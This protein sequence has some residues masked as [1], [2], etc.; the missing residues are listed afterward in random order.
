MSQVRQAL[1]TAVLESRIDSAFFDEGRL[2]QM[3]LDR[4]QWTVS[5]PFER[6]VGLKD[7]I[8]K[9]QRWTRIDD[10]WSYFECDWKPESWMFGFR[11][12]VVRQK[13]KKPTKGPL[14]LDLFTPVSHEYQ[15][16]VIMTNRK[17]AAPAVIDF[18][19]GRGS[20]EGIFA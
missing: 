20:Q 7:R 18:H 4:V 17:V 8:E 9:R 1:P 15:C 19:H 16:Q 2:L 6:F 14:Q 12:I 5:V 3:D 10:M 13:R 11:V